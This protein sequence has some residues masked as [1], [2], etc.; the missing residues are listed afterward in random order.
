MPMPGGQGPRGRP[1]I[2]AAHQSRRY[3]LHRRYLALNAWRLARARG[4]HFSPDHPI[5][6]AACHEANAAEYDRLADRASSLE[7]AAAWQDIA[8]HE[9]AESI[10]ILADAERLA[11]AAKRKGTH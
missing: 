2:G 4:L 8:D 9:M 1:V 7:D 6:R 3:A 11:R 10:A 5:A